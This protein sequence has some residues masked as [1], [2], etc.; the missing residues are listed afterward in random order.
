MM[1]AMACPSLKS[2][3]LRQ[4][5]A[6]D[7]RRCWPPNAPLLILKQTLDRLLRL[8]HAWLEILAFA[9]FL[10]CKAKGARKTQRKIIDVGS[11]PAVFR[12]IF[13]K[14]VYFAAGFYRTGLLSGRSRYARWDRGIHRG[15]DSKDTRQNSR[16]ALQ[17]YPR[18]L[19]KLSDRWALQGLGFW[20]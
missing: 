19:A 15:G 4:A 16:W 1:R 6:H 9:V 13:I 7:A 12:P 8:R 3:R 20:V 2:S 18:I 10:S 14:Y 11:H 5:H 17:G